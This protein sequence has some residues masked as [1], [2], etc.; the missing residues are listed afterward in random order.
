MGLKNKVPMK[1]FF[2]FLSSRVQNLEGYTKFY[3]S[4]GIFAEILIVSSPLLV[5]SL[6]ILSEGPIPHSF[7]TRSPIILSKCKQCQAMVS[8]HA[9]ENRFVSNKDVL[10]EGK[11]AESYIRTISSSFS[12]IFSLFSRTLVFNSLIPEYSLSSFSQYF[13]N[14]VSFELRNLWN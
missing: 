9:D 4:P 5:E 3:S 13:N 11:G 7:D 1:L 2:G 14:R 8:L 12:S 6:L 10:L